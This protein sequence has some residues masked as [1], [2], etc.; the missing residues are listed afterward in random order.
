[1]EP[2]QLPCQFSGSCAALASRR[3]KPPL[4][5]ETHKILKTSR[6]LRLIWEL[7]RSLTLF[8][9]KANMLAALNELERINSR[10]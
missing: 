7:Y 9:R 5:G 1:M 10:S 2:L 6:N 8:D 4:M 3:R